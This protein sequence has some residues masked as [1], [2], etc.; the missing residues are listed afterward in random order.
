M[1]AGLPV[2]AARLSPVHRLRRRRR[3]LCISIVLAVVRSGAHRASPKPRWYG[4][5]TGVMWWRVLAVNLD[6]RIWRCGRRIWVLAVGPRRHARGVRSGRSPSSAAERAQDLGRAPL[7]RDPGPV[8][9]LMPRPGELPLGVAARVV[10]CR[11]RPPRRARS[12]RS[13]AGSATAR[14]APSWRAA[15]DRACAPR[16]RALRRARPAPASRRKRASMRRRSSSRSG[17]RNTFTACAASS[18]GGRPSRC[19]SESARPVAS[20][21]SSARAMRVRS[22]GLSAARRTGSRR[23]S[24]ACSAAGPSALQA[25]AHRGADVRRDRRHGR[26]APASAP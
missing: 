24:S 17:A 15:A 3:H 9:K 10:S 4:A 25:R 13:D 11:P 6:D 22:P 16:A 1:V 20:S 21:T 7:R 2:L 8:R 5:T 26:R 18:S 14:R 23:A 19:Q 12:R